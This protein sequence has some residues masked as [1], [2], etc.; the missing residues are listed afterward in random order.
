MNFATLNGHPV[1]CPP[2]RKGKLS[3]KEPFDAADFAATIRAAQEK[4]IIPYP[5]PLPEVLSSKLCRKEA[6][7]TIVCIVCKKEANV[8]TITRRKTCSKE[9]N[10]VLRRQRGKE[11]YKPTTEETK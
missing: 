4:G 8:S 5:T 9:C 11:T 6:D 1:Y 3:T 7:K 2:S 10:L